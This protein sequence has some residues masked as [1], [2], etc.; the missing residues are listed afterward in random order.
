I[1][2]APKG[3]YVLVVNR[4]GKP[5][6]TEPFKQIFYP[7]V[8]ERERAAVITI[9][10]G[11]TV[12]NLDIIIPALEELI[13]IEGILRYSDGES[14]AEKFVKFKAT[15]NNEKVD[16]DVS[17]QT[18]SNGKFTLRVLKGGTGELFGEDWLMTG[19]Y[20]NCPKVDELIAKSGG[21]NVT[22]S[23]NVVK[24]TTEQDVYEVEL[25]LPFPRCEKAKE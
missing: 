18:D 6:S 9:G 8:S 17:E 3:E 16:G 11:E 4:S 15:Q 13:T 2:S 1:T 20:K 25:T 14:V 19:L 10:P 24:L 22:V 5:S 7:S 21:N 23:S 12:E